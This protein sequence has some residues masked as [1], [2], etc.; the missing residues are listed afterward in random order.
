MKR[1]RAGVIGVGFI[2]AVHIE[3]LRRLG[4]VDVVA[5]CD[6][7]NTTDLAERM[8]IPAAFCDYRAMI[9]ACDLDFIHICTPNK[10]HF[11]IASYA[12]EHGVNVIC[13]KPLTLDSQQARQ[14]LELAE[15]KGLVHA[16]NFH[17]RCY[18]MIRQMKEMQAVRK[19]GTLFSLH[20][21]YLQDWLL[22]QTDYS[23]RLEQEDGGASRVVADIGSHWI[24]TAEY[25]TGKRI[26]A[27]CADFATFYPIRIRP[28]GQVETFS[29][30]Q[31]LEGEPFEVK[32]EDYAQ[33]LFQ[34]EDGIKGSAV[35]SQTFAGLKNRMTLS[36][37]GAEKALSFDSEK[38][39]ELWV[40][41]RDDY[42]AIIVKD[43]GLLAA[44]AREM[45]SYPGGHVEGFGD[46][47]LHN[48]RQIYN[49]ADGAAGG[50][51]ATF[52][53]GIRELEVCEAI[54]RSNREKKWVT[55]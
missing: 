36:I 22:Y 53:D 42:N 29:G 20:G 45:D 30:K 26:S 17:S 6:Q 47:F 18:P 27:V 37:A 16:V 11:A 46:A 32:T 13:E 23:W 1:F 2:G 38:L 44:G 14:L 10:T 41:S 9:D 19:L 35:F 31:S 7:V 24:D 52:R 54:L 55:L 15:Q 50:E 25:V 28:S 21:G 40:G 49:R 5:L 43:P 48:F 3:A 12:L 8:G 51:F 33:I 39:N 34:W 4:N